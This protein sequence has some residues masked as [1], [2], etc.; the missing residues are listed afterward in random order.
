MGKKP[1]FATALLTSVVLLGSLG[2]AVL[3]ADVAPEKAGKYHE[4]LAR[5]PSPGYLFD[6]FYNAWLDEST[7]ENLEAFL[8]DRAKE[9]ASAD[10]LLLAFFHAKQGN[11]L[12]AI[13]QFRQ[14]LATDPGNAAAWYE[15]G[16]VEA[17]TLDFDT[18]LADLKQAAEA[19]PDDKLAIQIAKLQGKLLVRNHRR[20]EAIDAWTKLLADHPDD[21]ELTEDVIELQMEEGLF[22]EA[23]ALARTLI[24]RTKDPYKQVLR[25]LRLGDTLHRGGKRKEAVE[26]Y[27]ATLERVGSETW[28]E[29]EILAQIERVFR[30]ENDLAALQSQ[31]ETLVKEHPRRVGI[32]RAYARVLSEAGDVKGA[33][34]KFQEI[35]K[36]TP[37]DRANQE[38]F[39]AL[40]VQ[41][42]DIP[43]AI[44]HLQTLVEQ[45]PQDG[46][47]LVQLAQLQAKADDKP[48]ADKSIEQFLA[49]SDKSE[50]SYLRAARL[51]EQ[52]ELL[53]SAKEK[54]AALAQAFPDSVSAKEA[55]AAFLYK[56]GEKEP[57]LEIW[58]ALAIDADAQ[59]L[60]R[61]ARTLATRNEHEAAYE[62][63]EKRHAQFDGDWLFLGQLVTEALAN[64]KY[65]EAIPWA[66]ARVE[67][68]K[69]SS[70]LNDAIAQAATV[71][72][73]AEQTTEMVQKLDAAEPKSLRKSC[74][75]AE[76]L[77]LSSDSQR[78]DAM[79]TAWVE[80][81]EPLA[82]MQQVRLAT[83]RYDWTAAAAAMRRLIDLPGERTSQNVRRMIEFYERD[84][85]LEEAL[86]WVAEWKK[87][88]PGSTS[89]W[90][91][92]SRL[93]LLS[94]TEAA[95]ID[96]LRQ[97]VKEF[98]GNEEIR[99][100]LAQ[101]YSNTGKY[102]DAQRIYW[103]QF[104]E[105]ESLS[106]KLRNVDLLARLAEQ[107][108]TIEQLVENFEER[109]RTDRQAVEPLL[110]LAT[111]HRVADNYEN[112]RQAL[113]EASKM[114]PEDLEL[115][116][117]I[118]RIEEQEGDWER[119]RA[120]LEGALKL[121][122]T[123]R[124]RQRL[125][126]L[127]LQYGDPDV[128]YTMLYQ[129]SGAE[130]SDPRDI[131]TVAD[132]MIGAG[133]W[134]RAKEL[135]STHTKQHPTDYRLRYLLAI[136]CEEE[137]ETGAAIDEFLATIAAD[138]EIQGLKGPANSGIIP[139]S[140]LSQLAEFLPPEA[141]DI[142][143]FQQGRY[144]AYSYRQN[145]GMGYA[146]A[147][148]GRGTRISL[149]GNLEQAHKHALMHLLSIARS[150]DEEEQK[151]LMSRLH[152]AGVANAELLMAVTLSEN[153]SSISADE[154]LE[155]FPDNEAIR[156]VLVMGMSGNRDQLDPKFY[157]DTYQ[158]F[159][160]ERPQLA[161]MAAVQG[162]TRDEEL[163]SLL[164]KMPALLD[165]LEKPNSMLVMQLCNYL[166]RI[167][168]PNQTVELPESARKT[169]SAKLIEWYPH[170][171][172]Q[173]PYGQHI[174]MY[175]ANALRRAGDAASY[176]RLLEDEVVRHRSGAGGPQQQQQM[177]YGGQTE[178]FLN[179]PQFPP[180]TLADFPAAVL[181]MLARNDQQR[182]PFGG[183]NE[184][185]WDSQEL[186]KL[187]LQVKDPILRIL[188]AS[189]TSAEAEGDTE[190]TSVIDETLQ[191][192]LA[193]K[194]PMLDAY[195]LGAA[196]AASQ[197]KFDDAIRLYEKARYLPMNRTIR[198]SV[199]QS[200]VAIALE[201]AEALK[202]KP[203]LAQVARDAALRLRHG[204]MQP[205]ERSELV[206]AL[207]ELGLAKEAELL[208]KK[209]ASAG[210][211]VASR[212]VF[213][214]R[215]QPT[216]PDQIRR[217]ID[218]GK[219]DVAAKMLANEALAMIRQAASN[220][221]NWSYTQHQT[222]Q[223]R[224]RIAGYR[225]MDEVLAA[226]DPKQETNHRKWADFGM[227][228]EALEKL[229]EAQKCYERA[230]E[231]RPKEDTYR[232]RLVFLMA[233]KDPAA[234]IK[235]C[236]GFG[237]NGAAQLIAEI[238][239]RMFEH[240]ES[241]DA[242]LDFADFSRA[243]FAEQSKLENSDLSWGPMVCEAIGSRMHGRNGSFR[244]L[245]V[246]AGTIDNYGGDGAPKES[247]ERRQKLH[248]DFCREMLQHAATAEEAFTLLLASCEARGEAN[249][250][251]AEIARAT[252][253]KVE[254][255]STAA[256][257]YA[258]LRMYNRYSSSDALASPRR[259]AAEF[260]IQ[261]CHKQD[262]W[263]SLDEE[264]L[265]HLKQV[266]RR[267]L[268]DEIAEYRAL[269]DCT[270]EEFS[271]KAE[272][273]ARQARR[274]QAPNANQGRDPEHLVWEAW[275][276]RKLETDLQPLMLEFAEHA[277][278]QSTS[279]APGF[280]IR[281]GASLAESGNADQIRTWYDALA[282]VYLGPPDKRE[283]Y[284]KRN[285]Q[286]NSIQHGS[287][288]A[289]IHAFAAI[290][291]AGLQDQRLLEPTLHFL[292][293]GKADG[294]VQNLDH[295]AQ[296]G[297][298]NA[299]VE[300]EPVE[301][302]AYLER[303]GILSEPATFAAQALTDTGERGTIFSTVSTILNGLEDEKQT[304]IKK[305]LREQKSESFGGQ[306]LLAQW[307]KNDDQKF[308][309]LARLAPQLDELQQMN[310]ADASRLAKAL[311]QFPKN[312]EGEPAAIGPLLD[313]IRQRNSE[314]GRG[315]GQT[316]KE[317]NRFEDLKM[318]GYDPAEWF[319]GMLPDLVRHDPATAADAYFK[320]VALY[321]DAMQRNA[322]SF[323]FSDPASEMLS[324]STSRLDREDTLRVQ[325]LLAVLEHEKGTNLAFTV[326]QVNEMTQPVRQK[327]STL[328]TDA[329]KKKRP[330]HEGMEQF[331]KWLSEVLRGKTS[332]VLLTTYYRA[333]SDIERDAKQ[334]AEIEDWL[335]EQVA[336]HPEDSQLKDLLAALQHAETH[337][338]QHEAQKA[339]GDN[340]PPP[341][342]VEPAAY[343]QR[344]QELL[345]DAA[346]PLPARIAL[347]EFMFHEEHESLP[348]ELAL[349]INR[350]AT[351]TCASKVRLHDSH[352]SCFVRNALA[353]RDDDNA[354]EGVDSYWS[355]WHKRFGQPK[356][357]VANRYPRD[358]D[359]LNGGATLARVL[360][361]YLAVS[362][363]D[364]LLNQFMRK[365]D[366][367]LGKRHETF[368]LLL[369]ADRSELAMRV[370][371]S[372]APSVGGNLTPP[373][374]T[375]DAAMAKKAAE[376]L[377]GVEE[378]SLRYFASV[379]L[380]TLDDAKPQP[381][382]VPSRDERLVELAKQL[383]DIEWRAPDLQQKA[384]LMLCSSPPAQA[385][386]TAELESVADKIDLASMASNNNSEPFNESVELVGKRIETGLAKGDLAP[387]TRFLDQ[388]VV[389]TVDND[390]QLRNAFQRKS[391]SLAGGV[392]K[393]L[394]AL[395]DEQLRELATALRPVV[396]P[397]QN[398]HINNLSQ[399]NTLCA[400]AHVRTGQADQF[401]E[402]HNSL[403]EQARNRLQQNPMASETWE[404]LAASFGERTGANA[405][406]RLNAVADLLRLADSLGWVQ[407]D[408]G[409]KMKLKGQQGNATGEFALTKVLSEEELLAG[410]EQLAELTPASGATACSLAV[411]HQKANRWDETIQFC[412]QALAT[413][414]SDERVKRCRIVF[415]KL[416]ALR[417]SDQLDAAREVFAQ[418]DL[419]DMPQDIVK[420][421]ATVKQE[422]ENPPDANS[423]DAAPAS[424]ETEPEKT[425][426]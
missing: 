230:L 180:A 65:A 423:E 366:E 298:R 337:R 297:L 24:E 424:D 215:G 135:L 6:R 405:A 263:S 29:R 23:A 295:Y 236:E 205:N 97:A 260:L 374:V 99:L 418:I 396:A 287:P 103:L 422:L 175:A 82:V 51:L 246:P 239:G 77:E 252:L 242:R 332:P 357:V 395:S 383:K 62:I 213:S 328:V 18:A 48:A 389:S 109:R 325:L 311:A 68:S 290:L 221:G 195:L 373:L 183:T 269:F 317:A 288:N 232:T 47:L 198:R 39:I 43:A 360:A 57:A 273:Y 21:E 381:E 35:L 217:L 305:L 207:E 130:S 67:A 178:Q 113:A 323:Y 386:A 163:H 7:V 49:G 189:D 256:G 74:L 146:M 348:P 110:A 91:A 129:L 112:R 368:P 370:L 280:L 327:L 161:L 363:D 100:Q 131:E 278:R 264:A 61:L 426:G 249:D 12:Q 316:L 218:Q 390:W 192:L 107:Q 262:N 233:K 265:P 114:K 105:S 158:Q 243:L 289:Q 36:L 122:K 190:A 324:R 400:I 292:R 335:T 94:G 315:L 4:V 333:F 349:A 312:K 281:Y 380:A 196:R 330:L 413:I 167:N 303:I 214:Q 186:A 148:G 384:L 406:E 397:P 194:T 235:L 393:Q 414:P 341:G 284:I 369:Q 210:T 25:E 266:G 358:A 73:R 34:E 270:A 30:R 387:F 199:D 96:T 88:S 42:Q 13:E 177:Y 181:Q 309:V 227:V 379:W 347:A 170:V 371:R 403:N 168:N 137:A 416:R 169:L 70:D 228:N 171:R 87:L 38:A 307:E 340:P 138:A 17:R 1:I 120:T 33:I 52:L 40:F 320:L 8:V 301:V 425:D 339:E 76:L 154:L 151:Q 362:D 45:H 145:R 166:G 408:N 206:A 32:H 139:S 187:V 56:L 101:L 279:Q 259:S 404:W 223:L 84:F 248:D 31:Y 361:L 58:R 89:P 179:L 245:Y 14:T 15:K 203:E 143:Q 410:D 71:I 412:D 354:R 136:A 159:E 415:R 388:T 119:A 124:T 253:L 296:M 85:R 342:R 294:I 16:V 421:H 398:T 219:R 19:K 127:H 78:A 90:L 282:T 329:N 220:P 125:A 351:E 334:S 157:R 44:K 123:N 50:Y 402:W 140:Y 372:H 155:K 258:Q 128:G 108:G 407:F 165:R 202:E 240:E 382:G 46:E 2:A 234:A 385:E 409:L 319:A 417:K 26:T 247:L 118:A 394:G 365:Y 69:T 251:L 10:G 241:F 267:D 185:V 244:P 300:Q 111:I 331:Q 20:Q 345:A 275:Q 72:E 314:Y 182:N 355:A 79:L 201:Q 22:D 359:T 268:V 66:L 420:Q 95:A 147:A 291:Q 80:K 352:H 164:E 399:W 302:V 375:Y 229:D 144:T 98:D 149:P 321:E 59:Q 250:E 191:S 3:A 308:A 238:L 204:N 55:Q 60:V 283:E 208:D 391:Q 254:K 134:Q 150:L 392:A 64:K 28:L 92:Q 222:R 343:H 197:E 104:E 212:A 411:F 162:A 83:R 225:L 132:A 326:N 152:G 126:R 184:A 75:M 63:L 116:H 93:Q 261:H 293:E 172:N 255:P 209:T 211:A 5:R 378:P 54:Y 310:E 117:E 102:A 115:L 299:L 27:R 173:P 306:L 121:D 237:K 356:A 224:E 156:A 276:A 86:S 285:Y 344:Y 160:K 338:A 200:L 304:Q 11:D 336:A 350:L 274:G 174:F 322:V 37:G 257:A 141:I 188:L 376:F 271:D 153:Q 176:V 53:E 364:N 133:D 142:V 401:R 226:L 277:K 353:L 313:W 193:E 41:A 216:T 9:G 367:P 419:K 106:D 346:T 318:V 81:G 272:Q 286:R 377:A 231:L